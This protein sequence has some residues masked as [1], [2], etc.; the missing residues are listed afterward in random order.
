MSPH[1]KAMLKVALALGMCFAYIVGATAF[2]L[3]SDKA[4]GATVKGDPLKCSEL[5]GSVR[6]MAKYRDMGMTWEE[7]NTILEGEIAEVKGDPGSIVADDD[8]VAYL[9]ET[10]HGVWH[11]SKDVS[12]AQ[13]GIN[14]LL[15]CVKVAKSV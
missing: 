6:S 14:V 8:D 3:I 15:A 5:A 10:A 4:E 2:V 7:A 9:R 12:P 13:L 1:R 11:E